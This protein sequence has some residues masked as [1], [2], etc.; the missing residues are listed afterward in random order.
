M[1]N[2]VYMAACGFM[3]DTATDAMKKMGAIA[4]RISVYLIDR[5]VRFLSMR[6]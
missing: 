1:P 2:Q 6:R 4:F 3:K 5:A